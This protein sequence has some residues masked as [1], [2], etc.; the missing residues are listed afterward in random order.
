MMQ[1]LPPKQPSHRRRLCGRCLHPCETN[2]RG[3][4]LLLVLITGTVISLISLG[5]LVVQ[6]VYLTQSTAIKDA[7]SARWAARSGAT[8]ATSEVSR[9]TAWRSQKTPGRWY[10]SVIL[11]AGRWSLDASDPTDTSFSDSVSEPVLLS[12]TGT[13]GN[14]VQKNASLCLAES[15][16]RQPMMFHA[17]AGDDLTFNTATVNGIG[18]IGARDTIVVSGANSVRTDVMLGNTF[19]GSGLL[20]R[21][22]TQATIDALPIF[23]DFSDLMALGTTVAASSIPAASASTAETILNPDFGRG[24]I[25][26]AVSPSGTLTTSS[27]GGV[28][29][30]SSAVVSGRSTSA[31]GLVHDVTGIV[32]NGLQTQLSAAVMPMASNSK[33]ELALIVTTTSGTTT[34]ASWTSATINWGTS[35]TSIQSI[36]TTVT[37]TWTGRLISAQLKIR[38]SGSGSAGTQNFLVDDVSMKVTSAPAG[39][40]I[41]RTVVSNGTNPFGVTSNASGIY[42]LNCGGADL[43]ISDSMIVGTLIV[44]SVGT[45][46]V[47]S[48]P[49]QWRP[50][51]PGMPALIV[52][53]DV[54]LSFGRNGL[55]ERELGVNLNPTSS[56]D[57]NGSTDSSQNDTYLPELRGLVFASGD[58]TMAGDLCLNGSVLAGDDIVIQERVNFGQ[59]PQ[60]LTIPRQSTHAT[61]SFLR[62]TTGVTRQFD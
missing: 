10:S 33:F 9:S 59:A 12:S 50:A 45:V 35:Y 7:T 8:L 32:R 2:R 37:P 6:N 20:S 62:E 43:T 30:T 49:I 17:C 47:G 58:V 1:F 16:L 36:S 38:T 22:V 54:V 46:R 39:K 53:G 55:T 4:L 27:S 13:F 31:S 51:K 28:G 34:A 29:N 21:V 52:D 5:A 24:E 11:D 60:Y 18:W 26:W 15:A 14:A 25:G 3:G 61:Q 19:S 56:P 48:G 44:Q 57:E 23:S 42:V 40:A 41:Y